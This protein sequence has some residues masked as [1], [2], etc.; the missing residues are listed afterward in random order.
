MK[1]LVLHGAVL[2]NLDPDLLINESRVA[3]LLT[4][5]IKTYVDDAMAQATS[6]ASKVG[7]VFETLTQLLTP[8][9]GGR[10]DSMHHALNMGY[11]NVGVLQQTFTGLCNVVVTLE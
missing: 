9:S 7:S 10:L 3:H 11:Q 6:T 8:G 2:D 4:L 5:N 1:N